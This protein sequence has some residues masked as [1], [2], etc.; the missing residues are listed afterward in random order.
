MKVII[1]ESQYNK[2]IDQF[3][4]YCLEPHEV[5]ISENYPESV[6]WVKSGIVIVD[7]EDST[8]FW[9][10]REKWDT[11]SNMFGFSENETRLAIIVWLEKHYGL[12]SLNVHNLG[13]GGFPSVNIFSN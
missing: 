3:I 2:A 1:T 8:H 5:K 10:T 4:S 11:I 9:L 7:I 13:S 12:G 6:F